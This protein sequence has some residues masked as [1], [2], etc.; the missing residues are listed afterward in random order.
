MSLKSVLNSISAK[1]PFNNSLSARWA[2]VAFIGLLVLLATRCASADELDVGVGSSIVH[3]NGA[4]VSLTYRHDL[5]V[6]TDPN[7][8]LRFWAG[9]TMVASNGLGDQ[10]NWAWAG[11]LEASRGYLH[12]GI[13]AAY[14]ARVDSLNGEHANYELYL[15]YRRYKWCPIT[16]VHFSDAGTSSP[17]VGRNILMCEWKLR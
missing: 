11:G 8:P 4:A 16:L 7:N 12:V 9:T 5:P 13:G 1:L 3:G 15:S 2:I 10:S 17:N 6:R 14:L